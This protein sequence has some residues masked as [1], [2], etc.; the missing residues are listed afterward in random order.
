MG[1]EGEA[2]RR[3]WR[4]AVGWRGRN[5]G[6]AG[7]VVQA[8]ARAGSSTQPNPRATGRIEERDEGG[9]FFT[10]RPLCVPRLIGLRQINRCQ[11]D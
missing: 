7:W 1:E 6:V 10:V 8:A 3:R 2:A 11:A 9:Y 4:V 5:G